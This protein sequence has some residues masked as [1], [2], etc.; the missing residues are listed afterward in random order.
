MIRDIYRKVY[1]EAP[2]RST[3]GPDVPAP[4]RVLGVLPGAPWEVVE[5][6]YRAQARLRHPDAGGSTAAMQALNAAMEVIREE[7]G[8]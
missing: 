4:Y 1:P 3:P 7:R 8:K 5:A 6:A 2:P